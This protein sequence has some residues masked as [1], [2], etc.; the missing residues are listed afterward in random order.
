MR[1]LDEN[2]GNQNRGINLASPISALGSNFN[3]MANG[4]FQH[5]I[6]A[7]LNQL[8]RNASSQSSIEGFRNTAVGASQEF[9]QTDRTSEFLF[10]TENLV[11]PGTCH[12]PE[13]GSL[14]TF[15]NR[16]ETVWKS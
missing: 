9:A 6:D 12:I 16:R 4:C 1:S 2:A 13:Q 11:P 14:N 7:P 8:I 3:W 15:S 5:F 10:G